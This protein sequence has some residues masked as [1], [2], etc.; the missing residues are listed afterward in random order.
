MKPFLDA[1][2]KVAVIISDALRYECGEE[3]WRKIRQEN[4][5][6]AR[7]SFMQSA[8]PSYTQLGMAS[9]LPNKEIAIAKMIRNGAGRWAETVLEPLTVQ[10]SSGRSSRRT[11]DQRRGV[12]KLNKEESRIGAR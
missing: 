8:L 4:R 9:L 11:G 1:N 2:K 10:N 6:E 7:L 12:L 5:Y 3:L